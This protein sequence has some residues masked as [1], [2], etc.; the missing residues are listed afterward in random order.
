M[1]HKPKS[2]KTI[3]TT[4]SIT[5]GHRTIFETEKAPA[6]PKVKVTTDYRK[7]QANAAAHLDDKLGIRDLSMQGLI[8]GL[9]DPSRARRCAQRLL[10]EYIKE[11]LGNPLYHKAYRLANSRPID[12]VR[13]M[14]VGSKPGVLSKAERREYDTRSRIKQMIKSLE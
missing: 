2:G 4:R 14:V 5:P 11:E 3:K 8:R 6:P 9:D 10:S 1:F 13:Y 7:Y 12:I